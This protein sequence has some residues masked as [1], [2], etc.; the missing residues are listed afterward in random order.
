MNFSDIEMTIPLEFFNN[1][2]I[3]T[4]KKELMQYPFPAYA[5]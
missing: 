5:Q 4:K 2:L 1:S 3:I